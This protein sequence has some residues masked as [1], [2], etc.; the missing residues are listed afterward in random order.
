MALRDEVYR[1]EQV[2]LGANQ[3]KA[4]LPGLNVSIH[5]RLPAMPT[6]ALLFGPSDC[7]IVLCKKHWVALWKKKSEFYFFD[8]FGRSIEQVDDGGL[9]AWAKKKHVKESSSKLQQNASDVKT[10]G[11]HVVTRLL[12]RKMTHSAYARWLT[13]AFLRAD[14]TVTLLCYFL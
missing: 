13:H 5:T 14:I 10:C 9:K 6:D 1:K 7:A 4:M 12:K 11:F 3:L 8:S 2:P